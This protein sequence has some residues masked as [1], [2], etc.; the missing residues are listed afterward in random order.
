MSVRFRET[1]C[2]TY[3]SARFV[4]GAKKAMA[5]TMALRYGH[6]AIFVGEIRSM[7]PRTALAQL[8]KI[9]A[10]S[11]AN[12]EINEGL[13]SVGDA[14]ISSPGSLLDIVELMA[15]ESRQKRP[16]ADLLDAFAFMLEEVYAAE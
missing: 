11:M 12:G 6:R 15:A 10:M 2:W 5:Q 16:K 1:S 14:L 9:V 7:R 8:G 13:R 3:R 4:P